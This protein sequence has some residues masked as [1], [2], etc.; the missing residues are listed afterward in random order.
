MIHWKPAEGAAYAARL[1]GEGFDAAPY[2]TRGAAGFHVFRETP[3]DAIAIDLGEM[4]SY[5][6]AMGTLL[7]ERKST[8]TI[9]LV[10]LGGDP[11]KVARVRELLPDAGY[12]AWPGAGE[13]VRRAMLEAPRQP[14][15][16]DTSGTP[17]H[18]KLRI[19]AGA[20][21]AA[22][23]AP[24]GFEERLAPLPE[25][26][27]LQGHTLDAT[28]ILVFVR[29]AAALG[30]ELP[31]LVRLLEEPIQRPRTLWLMWPKKTSP[32]ARDLSLTG[33]REMCSAVDL[34]DYKICA[35]DETWSGMAFAARRT[36]HTGQAAGPPPR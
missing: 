9:P 5:G 27:R 22:L 10:F 18:R 32:L 3:P 2:A 15:V 11:E 25:G 1:R 14:I 12:G 30:H 24:A 8:R 7:R 35:V 26:V 6:R 28:V 36:A 4:P 21:V 34:V 33:I 19:K 17:L 29:S 13:A 31:E 20:A 16:P 23:H